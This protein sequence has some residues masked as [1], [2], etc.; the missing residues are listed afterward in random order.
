[1]SKFKSTKKKF[2]ELRNKLKEKVEEKEKK[3]E[4]PTYDDSWKF[5]PKLIGMKTEYRVRFLP[6]TF[7]DD[8]LS[9]PWIKTYAH[10][11]NRQSDGKFI[12]MQCPTTFDEKAFDKCPVCIKSKELYAKET[13]KAE[14][15][16]G[17]MYRKPRYWL[18]VLVKEDPRK[19][20]NQE[21]QVLVWE[22]GQQIFDKLHDAL[23]D[24]EMDF[25]D[26][27]EGN[28]FIIKIKKKGG[29]TNYEMSHFSVKPTPISEDEDEMNEIHDKIY[30]LNEKC[31]RK[32]L[33]YEF[34]ESLMTGEKIEKKEDKSKTADTD[35]DDE[36]LSE[37]TE[38]TDD[39]ITDDEL[40]GINEKTDDNTDADE[41]DEDTDEDTGEEEDDDIDLDELFK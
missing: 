28:D 1:M 30:N 15:L 11:F 36:T 13:E 18:N 12:Y 29:Y 4:K 37:D 22:V 9:E 25:Y 24:Q 2:D 40:D 6:H 31:I 16:A 3:K 33:D 41:D 23:V 26:P 35:N 38:E 21:G 8:G 10:M 5:S 14:E 20:D 39:D 34:I 32:E 19:E 27:E 17:K 7:V